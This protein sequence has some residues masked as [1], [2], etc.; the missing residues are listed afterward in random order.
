MDVKI[1]WMKDELEADEFY[2]TEAGIRNI[3]EGN[4]SHFEPALIDFVWDLDREWS[5]L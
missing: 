5:E 3:L 2:L 1:D 4:D